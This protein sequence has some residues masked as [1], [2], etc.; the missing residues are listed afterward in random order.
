M[1]SLLQTTGLNGFSADKIIEDTKQYLEIKTDEE[2]K[3]LIEKVHSETEFKREKIGNKV[4]HACDML[5]FNNKLVEVVQYCNE[6]DEDVLVVL[7]N[8]NNFK[9][10]NEEGS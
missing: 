4:L 7:M 2:L 3:E 8:D 10:K 5:V 9:S 6:R 1:I